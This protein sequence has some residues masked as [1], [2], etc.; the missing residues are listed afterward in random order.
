M[1]HAGAF[2]N[3][4]ENVAPRDTANGTMR[5]SITTAYTHGIEFGVK[6]TV[7]AT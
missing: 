6:V 4:E 2:L 1:A 3:A 5:M 7:D